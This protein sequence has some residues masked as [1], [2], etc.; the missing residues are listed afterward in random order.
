MTDSQILTYGGASIIYRLM[1][2][3]KRF[4]LVAALFSLRMHALP[5]G[6]IADGELY[7]NSICWNGSVCCKYGTTLC[8]ALGLRVGFYGDYVYNRFLEVNQTYIPSSSIQQT[9]L[10][11]NAGLVILN[12][13]EWLDVFATLGTTSLDL[14]TNGYSFANSLGTDTVKISMQ[15]P[16]Q[17]SWSVGMTG[18]IWTYRCF[19]FGFEGQYFRVNP[20]LT[21]FTRLNTG[22]ADY[23]NR[24][25]AY[26][27]WQAGVGAAYRFTTGYSG[28]T[29]VPYVGTKWSSGKFSFNDYTFS[30]PGVTSGH[31][32]LYNLTPQKSWGLAVGMTAM[33]CQTAGLN[34]EGRWADESALSV[35]GQVRF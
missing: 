22:R 20:Q 10:S 1:T 33:F 26:Q 8:Q 28:V 9:T 13:F 5:I 2:I 15:F 14:S 35:Q 16:A 17:F 34:I 25:T 18:T 7:Q 6:N 19:V 29:F 32:T 30:F 21:N 31:Y 12:F 27:E 23:L 24:P 3:M 4:A 11:T